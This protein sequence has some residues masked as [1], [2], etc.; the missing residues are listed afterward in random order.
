LFPGY[1]DGFLAISGLGAN[2]N[3]ALQKPINGASKRFGASGGYAA[4]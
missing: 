4:E 3:Q 1:I 2:S